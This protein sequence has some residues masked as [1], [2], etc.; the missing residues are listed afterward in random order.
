MSQGVTIDTTPPVIEVVE[1]AGTTQFRSN[2]SLKW[3]IIRDDESEVTGLEW[4][5]GTRPGSSD[6]VGWSEMSL[7]L[8][9]EMRI[10]GS[11]LDLYDGEIVFASL[12]VCVHYDWSRQVY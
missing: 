2:F 1:L 4:G 9:S 3:N 8:D 5:L 12:K 10:D 6:I 11:G 7:Q